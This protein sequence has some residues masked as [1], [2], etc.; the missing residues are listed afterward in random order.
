MKTGKLKKI[1]ASVLTITMAF[2]LIAFNSHIKADD[3]QDGLVLNKT[4]TWNTDGTATI[5]LESYATGKITST[6]SMTPTDIVLLLDV[7]GSMSEHIGDKISSDIKIDSLKNAAMQFV[8]KTL[9]MNNQITDNSQKHRISI[10]KYAG[11]KTDKI[12]ND[13]YRE[14]GNRYNY[15]Q[16]VN[17]LTTVDNNTAATMNQEIDNFKPGGATAADWG[18][19]HTRTVLNQSGEGRNKVVIMFTDG[20]PNH[21]NDFDEDVAMSAIKIAKEL[22]SNKTT[23]YSVS[24]MTNANPDIKDNAQNGYM[25]AISSN[26]PNA[27]ADYVQ[28]GRYSRFEIDF[29]TTGGNNGYYKKA[30]NSQELEDIFTQISEDIGSSSIDLDSKAVLS[31]YISDSFKCPASNKIKAYTE[32]YN[33]KDKEWTKNNDEGK[34]TVSIDEKNKKIDVTGFDYSKNY[35]L[36][37]DPTTNK[38]TGNKLVVEIIVNPIDGFVGGNNVFTNKNESGIYNNDEIVKN[39][40]MPDVDV[41]LEYAPITKD[42]T[43]YIGDNWKEVQK[44]ISDVE[45]GKI[46]FNNKRNDEKIDE[47]YTLDG[48]RNQYVDLVYSIYDEN[49]KLVATYT[50]NA[51]KT[52]GTLSNVSLDTTQ[53]KDCKQFKVNVNVNPISNGEYASKEITGQNST[54]H[55]LKPTVNLT[56]TTIFFGESTNLNERINSIGDWS[57]SHSNV[58]SPT[59]EPNISYEFNPIERDKDNGIISDKST[60]IPQIA[61]DTD[62]NVIIKNNN[63]DITSSTKFYNADKK[64]SDNLFTVYVKTG[65]ISIDKLILNS[66]NVDFSDGDPIFVFKIDGSNNLLGN[67]TYYRYVRFTSKDQLNS[68]KSA[69]LIKGLPTGQYKV[70]EVKTLRYQFDSVKLDGQV[71]NTTN[72][73]IDFDIT[74]KLPDRKVSYTNKVKSKDYDSDNDVLINKFVKDKDG[75]VTI[76]QEKLSK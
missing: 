27:D 62:F 3:T 56:D 72:S 33:G 10:V 18:F 17:N 51:G 64:S 31:D 15:T 24:V 50:I 7:S 23:I 57:C 16:I 11:N 21:Y 6:T 53:Y 46:N 60:F 58:P 35:V 48:K 63:I 49:D 37:E 22:K 54:L 20:E 8:N 4:A 61:N 75:K 44:F 9:E 55:V 13:R 52:S 1:L 25:N 76:V 30:S 19:E 5:R 68:F 73:K 45:N 38:P 41:P 67:R 32:K 12:G 14:G 71:I 47:I 40:N 34:Y 39:F 43:I 66:N 29:G 74:S 69:D 59:T 65:S 36:E 42:A 70:E 28:Y 2:T 26:Y